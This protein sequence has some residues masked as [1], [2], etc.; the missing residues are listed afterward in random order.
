VVLYINILNKRAQIGIIRAIGIR[1]RVISL[2]YIYVSLFLGIIGSIFG[3]IL[4]KALIQFFVFNPIK[5]GIGPLIPNV[6]YNVFLVVSISIILAS[7][8]SGYLVSKKVVKY[9]IIEAIS[10]G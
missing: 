6:S 2:S 9:N 5:T 1:S 10:N 7:V 8:I 4:T 3:I